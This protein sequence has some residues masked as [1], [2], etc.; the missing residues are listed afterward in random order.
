[1]SAT[2][3][4]QRRYD[5]TIMR[6]ARFIGSRSLLVLLLAACWTP[7]GAR[8]ARADDKD[9]VTILEEN[10]SLYFNSDKH[11]TQGLRLSDLRPDLPPDSPWNGPFDFLGRIAPIM[12]PD[13]AQLPRKRRYAVFF[14]QSIFTP[15][16]LQSKPPDPGDRPYAGWA[17]LGTSLLQAQS[18]MLENFEIDLGVVGPAALG[19][20]VQNYWHQFIGKGRAEGWGYQLRNEPGTM[21]SYERL[22]RVPL[23]GDGSDGVDIVP[24]AG[25]TAGNVMTYGAVGAQFRIGRNLG[26][27]FGQ[28]RVRPALSGTDYFDADRLDGNWGYYFFVGAQGRAVGRNIFL[29]GNTFRSSRHVPKKA[30]VADLQ[31]GFSIFWSSALRVDFSVVRRT[32]EFVG[33]RTP[34]EIGTAAVAFSW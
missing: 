13:G 23:V 3:P 14:G 17:Y 20:S 25:A 21:I 24:Q 16:N 22:W 29:D 8:E 5:G 18:Q 31:A 30:L 11:Y 19:E 12:Q 26:A 33:Q 15:K 10:D 27:D 4:P 32:E 9:R 28:V 2:H 7:L 6:K 34:D 1:M